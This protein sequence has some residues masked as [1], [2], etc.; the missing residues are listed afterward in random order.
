M[1][2][3]TVEA[4]PVYFMNSYAGNHLDLIFTDDDGVEYVIFGEPASLTG[5]ALLVNAVETS[6]GVWVNGVVGGILS[7]SF[8]ARKPGETAASRG[9]REIDLGGRDANDVWKIL[10]EHASNIA[11]QEFTYYGPS[12]N[13]NTLVASLLRGVG[14]DVSSYFPVIPEGVSYPGF[15][16]DLVFDYSIHGT[17]GTDFV[18]GN[19]GN[20]TFLTR[21]VGDTFVGAAGED[22]IDFRSEGSAGIVAEFTV[23]TPINGET[24]SLNIAQASGDI[25]IG[26]VEQVI[27]SDHSDR[28]TIASLGSVDDTNPYSSLTIDFGA[29]G[30][31][32]Q[33]DDLLDL[34]D[35]GIE[36]ATT[37]FGL[38][39]GVADAGVYVNLSD[40]NRQT[41]GYYYNWGSIGFGDIHTVGGKIRLQTKNANSVIGTEYDDFIVGQSGSA[42]HSEGYSTLY[43]G[44]GND[45]LAGG[46][47]ESHLYGGSGADK[48][49]VGARTFIEDPDRQDQDRT[50]FADFQLTGGV[51][52]AWQDSGWAYSAPMGTLLSLFP[53]VGSSLIL[54]GAALYD[55]AFM[56]SVRYRLLDDGTLEGQLGYGQAGSFYVRNYDIDLNSGLGAAGISVWQAVRASGTSLEQVNKV[57]N[58]ALYAGFGS[59]LPG[60]DPLVL[61]L[62]GDGYNLVGEAVSSTYFEFDGDG[63]GEHTGWVRASDGFLVR[64]TNGNGLID[65]ITE[66]FGNATTSGFTALGSYDS[67]SDDK[68][69]ASDTNFGAL[70]VWQDADQD[71]V[72]DAGEL[73]TLTELG[74]SSIGLTTT[75]PEAGTAVGGNQIVREGSFT[76]SDGSTGK[77][78]DVALNLNQTNSKWLGDSTVSAPASALP[79]LNG[80]GELKDLRIAMTGDAGLLSQV[81]AFTANSTNDLITLKAGTEEIL[82]KWAGVEGVAT[83]ALGSNG[84]NLRKLAF[85][86]KYTG[87]QLM[88]RDGS[89]VIQLTNIAEMEGMWTDQLTRQ[90]LRL[91]VQGPLASTF[92]GINYNI[93]RDLLV[94]SGPT[95][96]RDVVRNLLIAL[97]SDP[98]TAAA[99]WANWAP[100]IGVLA[101]GMVRSDAA[102]VRGDYV[103]AQL[104]AAM[105]GVVQPLGLSQ[106]ATA[107]NIPDLRIGTAASE[108]L[109]RGAAGETAIYYSGGGDDALNG[110]A[111]QD[112]YVFG[113]TV[114]HS[115]ITDIENNETGDRIR[116]ALHNRSEVKLERSGNDLLITVTTTGETVRVVG[117]FAPVTPLGGGALLSSNKGVEDVQFADGTIMELP[118]IMTAVGTGTDGADHLVGTM[119]ADI[120]TGG[121]GNDILEGGDDGDLY[122]FSR[123]D[124]A[125]TIRDVTTTPIMRAAD[126]L[127]LGDDVAPDELTISRLGSGGDDLLL[128]LANGG[129]SLLIQGQFDYSSL[130]YNDPL[131]INSRIE[132]F[133]F[134]EYGDNWSSREVQAKLIAQTTTTGSDTTRGFGDDDMFAGSAGNDTLI[135]MDGADVYSWNDGDGNDTIAEQARYIDINVGLGGI[136]LTIKADTIEFGPNVLAS[137]VIF[138]RLSA[139]P[140]LTIT[141][142]QTGET[143]TVLKQFAGFQ[144]GVL[145]AQ[146]FDRIE[147]FAFS[148]GSR[149][150]W[151]DVLAKI[152]TGTAGADQLWGDLTVD[153]LDGKAGD[154]VLSGLGYGDIYKF[155]LGYG[156][157]TLRDDN[158]SFLGDGFV[159]I[160]TTP[161]ILQLGAGI[162]A[163]NVSFARSGSDID[164]I[165]NGTDRVT[166]SGQDNYIQT[167]VFGP[168]SKDRI[169]E[170]RFADGTVWGWQELN[171][172]VIAGA[173]TSGNDITTGFTLED[174]FEAS[175]GNDILS[176]GDSADIYRFGIGSGQDVIRES[177]SNI[178]YGDNDK[179]EFA[180][181]VLAANV[182]VSRAGNDLILT[183]GAGDSLTIEGQFAY[184]AWFTWRDVESFHFADGTVWSNSDIS[185]KLLQSTSGNDTLTGFSSDDMLDGGA[186]NDLLIGADGNDTYAFGIGYGVDVIRDYVSN[187]NLGDFDRLVFGAGITASDLTFA[188][189]GDNLDITRNGSTDKVTI[190][191]QFSFSAWFSWWDIEQFVFADGSTLSDIDVAAQI[192]GGTPGDDNIVGTFRSDLIDGG[193]GNDILQGGDGSDR[194]VF[195]LGYGHDEIRENVSNV[196]LGDGD[197][198]EF[199]AGID[200]EDLIFSRSG[201]DLII[202]I[203]GTSDQL[204]ITGEF[205]YQ[206]WFTWRDIERF[207]LSDGTNFT[208]LDVQLKL[209]QG[210]SGEDVLTGFSTDDRLDGGAGNDIL[211]GGEGGDTYVFGRGYGHDEIREWHSNANLSEWD[212]LE[213]APDVQLSDLSFAREGNDVRITINDTGDSILIKG[214]FNHTQNLTWNDVDAFRFADGQTISRQDI[215]QILTTGSAGADNLSGF[216]QNDRFIGGPGDDSLGESEGDDTYVW[217]LGDGNDVVRGGGY[218]DGYNTVEF[219]PG[220]LPSD[221]VVGIGN[222]GRGVVLSVTGQPGSILIENQLSGGGSENVDRILFADGTAWD[223]AKI[224]E[225]VA[226]SQSTPGD[227]NVQ[228]TNGND[229]IYA[230]EGNDSISPGFG[231]DR[232]VGGPGDDTIWESDNNDTYVWNLGDGDD[233]IRNGGFWDGTNTIEFGADI[234]PSDLIYG[235][236]GTNGTHLKISVAGQPGSVTIENQFSGGSGERIDRLIF[237]DGTIIGR[238]AFLS[239]AF[240]Q[241]ATE[242]ADSIWGSSGADVIDGLGGD[243]SLSPGFG[244]DRLIA[245]PGNDTL[246]ESDND[247]TYVWNLGDGDDIIRNG[248]FWDGYNT[249]EFG[250]GVTAADLIYSYGGTSGTHLRISV[251]GQ[252]GSVIIENQLSGGAGERIDRLLFADGSALG[253]ADFQNAAFTQIATAGADS[254][255]GSQ[256]NDIIHGEDGDDSIIA[257]FGNDRVI[258]GLGN[259]TLWETDN[260]DT[261]VWN[262]GDGD[263]MIRNGGS[264]DGY[265]TI[266][267]GSGIAAADL[268]YSY[269][270]T[271]GT[272]LKISVAGQAGSITIENQLS[273]GASDRIDRLLFSDGSILNR[274]DFQNAAFAQIAT[275]S[276]ESL[277]GSRG[278]DIINGEGG[279]DSINPGFGNDRVIGG[280]GDDIIWESDNDDTYVWNIG[281]GNDTLKG[282][283]SWDGANILELG[284]GIVA[285]DVRLSGHS[286]NANTVVISFANIAGSI[287]LENQRS[288]DRVDVIRFADG[289]SWT[290][291]DLNGKFDQAKLGF[292]PAN[293]A[294]VVDAPNSQL[295]ITLSELEASTGS[296]AELSGNG[297][298]SLINNEAY[299]DLSH[300]ITSV[301]VAGV[302]VG[303]PSNATLL[304]WMSSDLVAVAGQQAFTVEWNFEAPE[305]AFDYLPEGGALTLSYVVKIS[306]EYGMSTNQTINVVVEGANDDPSGTLAS[307]VDVAN[308]SPLGSATQLTT[309]TYRL[310]PASNNQNGAVWGNVDLTLD[311]RWT[312]KMFFGVSDGGADGVAFGLQNDGKLVLGTSGVLTSNSLGIRF[313]TWTSAGLEPASDF[314]QIVLN[315]NIQAS[316]ADFDPFHL[317]SNI[318]NNAWHDVVIDW[319]A[320][321]KTLSYSYDGNTIASKTYDA[322]QNLFG[323]DSTV[324]FGFGAL[325]GGLNNDQRVQLLALEQKV[326]G[327]TIAENSAVGTIIGTLKGVDP[328]SG[329]V[330]SYSLVDS[331]GSPTSHNLFEIIGNQIRVKSGGTL[332]FEAASTHTL[333][334][335]VTD[336]VGGSAI[337]E[338]PI[339]ITDMVDTNVAPLTLDLVVNMAMP[340]ALVGSATQLTA[341]TYRLTP[342][343]NNKNG[344]VW[345]DVDLSLDARWTTKMFFGAADGGADGIAF[346]FQN[347]GK[348]VLGTSGV[349]TANSL[350]IRFD[351][352]TNPGVEPT[353]DFSQF[354]LSANLQA[355]SAAFDPFHLLPNIENNAWHDV[356]IDW[357][358]TTKTI[359]YSFDGVFIDAKSY[360]AVGNLFAGDNTVNFGFGAFTGG[361]NN[362]QRVQLLSLEQRV[363][364]FT[365]SE[366][367]LAGTIVGILRGT[368]LNSGDSLTYQIVDEN[369][370]ITTDDAF[371]IISGNRLAVKSGASLDYE[372]AASHSLWIKM[373]DSGAASKVE[374]ININIAD[375]GAQ[376][377]NGAIVS[378]ELMGSVEPGM[379]DALAGDAINRRWRWSDNPAIG[380]RRF[381][382][383]DRTSGGRA[384]VAFNYETGLGLDSFAD[385]VQTSSA[386]PAFNSASRLAEAIAG[387]EAGSGS[388]IHFLHKAVER[389]DRVFAANALFGQR[390]DAN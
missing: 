83:T 112:V 375:T 361:L 20:Q 2:K 226:G 160:D 363:S 195:G 337:I 23:G 38:G 387:F 334:A 287:T 385:A 376:Q 137:D 353:S 260:E 75:T 364:A 381:I 292:E 256:G 15:D 16:S 193:A 259:D 240:A 131:A 64:D 84:F 115:V 66:M 73:K 201:D 223:R 231:N 230:L 175:A 220:I 315:G 174:V 351:T 389:E 21:G 360:D 56:K 323:G 291:T 301:S 282:G 277:W 133:A 380:G 317:H 295:S 113:R 229:F 207:Q 57:V 108:T 71:G 78:A 265:N 37:L 185:A 253:R 7:E 366:N 264:W 386:M 243:D 123:G 326:S 383:S 212:T 241:L 271:S 258:G 306:D 164:L 125:D 377:L 139:A 72:T 269:G 35:A 327:F 187:N 114:G 105:D 354:V 322:V 94:A 106:L 329:D 324:N 91:A 177:V 63:F 54:L 169:E 284:T 199:K 81:S 274:I 142:S 10:V 152:T 122:I 132:A 251:A 17:T 146:W 22:T 189:D 124:G 47:W 65:N 374:Q 369:G 343:S 215:Q 32:H 347:S 278:A 156:H 13:S 325:T 69:D 362:D 98:V 290:R 367:S 158:D 318:E 359:S 51:Q 14:I 358:A 356:V 285:A 211:S 224:N 345:G 370:A 311:T 5:G 214:E 3:I 48:F 196:N 335:K 249:I 216:F 272:H 255:W 60:F 1:A 111:G 128:T 107:L 184:D 310:T 159:T 242:G 12:Q 181:G 250:S 183:L 29:A 34:S 227:D 232:V 85:L 239:A 261:Y 349:L 286:L 8:D 257:S 266:E 236:G 162:T 219:G 144:T 130:G 80:F 88:P 321:T 384:N 4:K 143:L 28:I 153:T 50:Y 42:N 248:G 121:K 118:E 43:G 302:T 268:V 167:G 388:D 129:G 209:L 110:G 168:L 40:K 166:L 30:V 203:A 373:E 161:D 225:K 19:E 331:E 36:N 217:N 31:P 61:D 333:H 173:T 89:G 246:W 120:L 352:W 79:Q 134:R 316:S 25:K 154:D 18:Q 267:F 116:F 235:Y 280:T 379:R 342:A 341:D 350:G 390:Y 44:A 262:L 336:N 52:K 371:E 293:T 279:D 339:V 222:S 87:T 138:S 74:I 41:V 332:D 59:G 228:G 328:D 82:Y 176:G 55:T 149:L 58:L 205:D 26:E 330:L 104:L 382:R 191:G 305:A 188:R 180:S 308:L 102:V 45:T 252:P 365:V 346:G 145:G 288:G 204:K 148:N 299:D 276:G 76:R 27:L 378:D 221:I 294:P 263:D 6:P 244:N 314:S 296:A 298:I 119:H 33:G 186:G 140:D 90:T 70:K 190:E 141:N 254:L 182:S 93:E 319:Q 273:G 127:I 96:L 300:S 101:D 150:S 178:L 86:E 198:V 218:W 270:G 135:G 289:T 275:E 238:A 233:I 62:N 237:A 368:D 355:T 171:R 151:Q 147:W 307:Y 170:I 9:S 200:Y 247:D 304:Q 49:S 309:D 372:T 206:N 100:L 179:V 313:D 192:T 109:S 312:T 297:I 95:A 77:I 155:G 163:A 320:A 344:A 281:D 126:M 97:P 53:S 136:S 11:A 357:N 303:I 157:D 245:G 213:F 67:N 117:Q 197:Q 283:G 103:V 68:I 46:G 194:Y 24:Q 202:D 165:I 348:A 338:V 172:R 208:K 234:A 99:Q 92:A 340:T 39:L 210:T